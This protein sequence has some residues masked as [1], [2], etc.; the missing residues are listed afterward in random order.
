MLEALSS[1]SGAEGAARLQ[2]ASPQFVRS[3]FD[4]F[5]DTF[6]EKLHALQYKVPHLPHPRPNRN[7]NPSPSPNPHPH[8]HHHPSPNLNPNPSPNPTKVPQLIGERVASLAAARGAP[9]A[10]ALDAGCGTGL[11]GPLLRPHVGG[12]LVGVDLL[13]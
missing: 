4:D 10:T 3:L 2:R 1:D 13:P 6:E 5:S 9:Y 8:H 12:A 7:P 11:A